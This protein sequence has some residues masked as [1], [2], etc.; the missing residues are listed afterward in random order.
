MQILKY[1]M[2]KILHQIDKN[3]CHFQN[4]VN[5]LK[6]LKVLNKNNEEVF[7]KV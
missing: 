4:F 2:N 6:M 5:L 1:S 7:K 3:F